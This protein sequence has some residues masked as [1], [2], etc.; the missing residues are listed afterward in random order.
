[1]DK[2]SGLTA[3]IKEKCGLG[4][5]ETAEVQMWEEFKVLMG[6]VIVENK[7]EALRAEKEWAD[8]S[9]TVWTDGSRREGEAVSA[10]LAYIDRENRWVKRG[11]YLGKNKEVFDAEV[12]AITRAVRLLDE[13]GDVTGF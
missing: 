10:A 3:R 2:R 7:E 1:M 13:M 5:T 8:Q 4:G 9:G 11:T 12:F 6:K